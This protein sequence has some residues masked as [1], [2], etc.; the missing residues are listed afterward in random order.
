MRNEPRGANTA[1]IQELVRAGYLV[2]T[3][4]DVPL[5][6]VLSGDT[7]QLQAAL[8]SG[9]RL[10]STTFRFPGWP[11]ATGRTSSRGCPPAASPAAIRSTR[12]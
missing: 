10:V 1:E 11:P 2:G 8:E 6:T 5:T 3:R 12:A 4:S 7:T 9:A